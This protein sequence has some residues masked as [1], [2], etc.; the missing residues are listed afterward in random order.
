VR[1]TWDPRKAASNSKKHGVSFEEAVTVFADPLA[2]IA[3]D[4][5]HVER[6]LIIGQST[7]QRVLV[8]V[9]V[10]LGEDETRIIS[11]RKASRSERRFYETAKEST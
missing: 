4:A 8:S 7:A 11:A 1:F 10:E 2:R 3:E 5:V 6:A 9:F